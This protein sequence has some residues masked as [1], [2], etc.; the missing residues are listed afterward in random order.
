M[1]IEKAV[2]IGL[3]GEKLSRTIT[4]TKEVSAGRS[5]VA[6]GSGALLGA[7]ATGSVVVAASAIGAGALATAAAP[8]VVPVA[9]VAGAVSFIRSLWD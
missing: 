9:A 8:V 2:F 3:A 5:V 7:T 1:A 6:A 4:G